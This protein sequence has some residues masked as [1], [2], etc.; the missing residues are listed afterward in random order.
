[1]VNLVFKYYS[2]IL[3]VKWIKHNLSDKITSGNRLDS[4]WYIIH[5]QWKYRHVNLFFARNCCKFWL[6]EQN[7]QKKIVMKTQ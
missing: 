3:V 2:N 1:M 7:M 6:V 5:R 4:M